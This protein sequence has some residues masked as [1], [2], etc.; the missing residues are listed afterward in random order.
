MQ[1]DT[2]GCPRQSPYLVTR[3]VCKLT[4]DEE[5]GPRQVTSIQVWEGGPLLLSLLPSPV[6]QSCG[7]LPV[8]IL[9]FGFPATAGREAAWCAGYVFST[10]GLDRFGLNLASANRSSV[11]VGKFPT[12]LLALVPLL[13]N[14]GVIG[15]Y[16]IHLS[17]TSALWGSGP[18]LAQSTR[19]QG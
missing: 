7:T 14:G 5:R 18:R 6:Q 16:Q 11:T 13:W 19:E 17:K 4:P 1:E 12:S 3:D 8:L 10:L 9:A 2:V 15:I